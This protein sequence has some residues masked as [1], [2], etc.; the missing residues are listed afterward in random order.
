M[1]KRHDAVGKEKNAC[2]V[3]SFVLEKGMLCRR[4]RDR[5]PPYCVLLLCRKQRFSQANER[6]IP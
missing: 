2:W 3:L 1:N 5:P 6:E 4:E